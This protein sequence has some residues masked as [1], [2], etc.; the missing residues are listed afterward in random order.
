MEVVPILPFRTLGNRN[1][2]ENGRSKDSDTLIEVM[3]FETGTQAKGNCID[4]EVK[5]VYFKTKFYNNPKKS[6]RINYSS[7]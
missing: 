7:K 3:I 5:I 6:K 2:S 4:F 1:E